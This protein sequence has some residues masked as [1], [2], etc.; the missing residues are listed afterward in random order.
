MLKRIH[1]R[2][3]TAGLIVG[4]IALVMA[5]AGGAWAAKGGLTGKQKKEVKSIATTVA[6]GMVGAGPPGATGPTGPKGD[7]GSAGAAGKDGTDG[8]DGEDGDPGKSIE[9]TP[10]A[11]GALECEK[12]GGAILEEE[13]EPASAIEVCNGKEGSPW[14]AGGILPP[15]STETGSYFDQFDEAEGFAPITFP[16]LLPAPNLTA[17]KV[18]FPTEANFVDFDETGGSALGCKG[19]AALPLAPPGHLCVYSS[20]LKNA[21]FNGVRNLGNAAAG[22]NRSG[23]L[24]RFNLG[25]EPEAARVSG[26][27]AV[28]A[29]CGSGETLVEKET[30]PG[31]FE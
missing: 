29:P 1:D 3:G 25:A 23:G 17:A 2:L 14:T 24:V 10:V 12:R 15:G 22:S 6:K 21:T 9:L 11:P 5:M 13:D 28:T 31:V 26:S 8:E 30:E 4:V 19:T 16:I 18:H 20:L 7:P 27:F